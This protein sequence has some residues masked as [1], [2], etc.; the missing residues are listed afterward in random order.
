MGKRIKDFPPVAR[1]E[2]M[3]LVCG[4]S[5]PPENSIVESEEELCQSS[6]RTPQKRLTPQND[7]LNAPR[8][9]LYVPND[10]Q[11]RPLT[12]SQDI[13]TDSDEYQTPVRSIPAPNFYRTH[14]TPDQSS[15]SYGNLNSPMTPVLRNPAANS[16]RRAEFN[17]THP[18][19][20]TESET[21]YS[22]NRLQNN[23]LGPRGNP[24]ANSL[25]RVARNLTYT[26]TDA[27]DLT[28]SVR[29]TESDAAD[30]FTYTGIYSM[31]PESDSE[32]DETESSDNMIDLRPVRNLHV[33]DNP[34]AYVQFDEALYSVNLPPLLPVGTERP[35]QPES[36]NTTCRRVM[37]P[38]TRRPRF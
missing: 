20:E 32:S 26:E 35:Q 19:I 28:Y 11:S 30:G 8:R 16:F 24:E 31:N 12:F 1:N 13:N 4:K 37:G 25:R 14:S 34:I 7:V 36:I 21:D 5:S 6:Y 29:E 10:L 23:S 15:T 22:L 17:L 3:N 9:K 18:A 38:H 33:D 2:S 27:G